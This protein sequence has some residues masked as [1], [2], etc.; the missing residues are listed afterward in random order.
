MNANEP[1]PSTLKYI[2]NLSSSLSKSSRRLR[3]LPKVSRLELN[4]VH[5]ETA[6]PSKQRTSPPN[7]VNKIHARGLTSSQ[8]ET[9]Y[10]P[11]CSSARVAVCMRLRPAA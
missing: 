9:M 6:L 5:P 3:T 11:A 1:T 2:Q 4:F 8:F 7:I 10:C